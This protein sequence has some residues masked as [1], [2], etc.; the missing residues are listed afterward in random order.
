MHKLFILA[1]LLIFSSVYGI[2]WYNEF[3]TRW[4][5]SIPPS[6]NLG[7]GESYIIRAYISMYR[8][9]VARGEPQ[10]EC[11]KWI[12]R[13]IEHCDYIVDNDISEPYLVSEFHG[14]TPIAWFINLIF[15][16][17]SLYSIY[18]DTANKYLFYLESQVIPDW[19]D[20]QY[21]RTPHN[22]YT[23]Y[24]SALLFLRRISRSPY[25][26]PPYY[27]TPDTTLA[28][29]YLNTL[30]D[31]ATNWF[32]DMGNWQYH[33][34]WNDDPY[35]EK[36]GLCY[37]PSLDAYVW[38]YA[39]YRGE[40][41]AWG[42]DASNNYWVFSNTAIDSLNKWY[43]LVL[44][45]YS[46]TIRFKI[47]DSDGSTLI[48]EDSTDFGAIGPTD[49]GLFFGSR[50]E[51]G[52]FLIGA[53][54]EIK[55]ERND[56]LI[57]YW[58]FEGNAADSSGNGR[59]GVIYGTPTWVKG[60][61]G[62]ALQF[63]GDDYV[64]VPVDPALH[65]FSKIDMW[66]KFDELASRRYCILSKG[67]HL[68][69]GPGG[70]HINISCHKRAEDDHSNIE[71]EFVNLAHHDYELSQ[72]YPLNKMQR[73]SNTMTKVIWTNTDTTNPTFR[74]YLNPDDPDTDVVTATMRWL[75]L[76]EFQPI[77]GP[78]VSKWYENHMTYLWEEACANLACWQA[79]LPI[80]GIEEGPDNEPQITECELKIYP[81]PFTRKAV[82]RFQIPDVRDQKSED[83]LEIYDLAGRLVKTFLITNNERQTTKVEWDGKGDN[84]KLMPSGIY[85]VKLKVGDFS[86]TKKLLLLR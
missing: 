4:P 3:N 34:G 23:A 44:T 31:I 43:R 7:W 32:Q 5:N 29:Y 35:P 75:W 85:F 54:D 14:V 25:Y 36:K 1:N 69:Y 45:H 15:S 59:H 46:D 63:S 80:V 51:I 38:R 65:D 10:Q 20:C 9:A 16:N 57:G 81:N 58:K 71:I 6:S 60:K 47:Y 33:P 73:F 30:T 74:G 84:E 72:F 12:D 39:D 56:K 79:G 8:A 24:G 55:I 40:L 11:Q 27:V 68:H 18:R 66:V 37:C 82:I 22:W 77:I 76:Y 42:F 86:Q 26:Q 52:D 41:L 49:G 70:Y 67:E 17:D 21:W 13:I 83:R 53:M 28:E 19:R 78:V 61:V 2:D 62:Q 50:P 64:R 48:W